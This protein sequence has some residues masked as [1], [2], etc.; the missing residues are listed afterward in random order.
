VRVRTGLTALLLCGCALAVRCGGTPTRLVRLPDSSLSV[1][2]GVLRLVKDRWNDARIGSPPA[3]TAPACSASVGAPPVIAGDFNGDGT[4]DLA[5]QVQARDGA[6][7]AVA[8]AR[9]KNYELLDVVRAAPAPM[10]VM[11]I[12]HRGAGYRTPDSAMDYFFS[13]DT[14]LVMPC[15]GPTTAYFWNGSG[16][17]PQTV[18]I[19]TP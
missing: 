7:L 11:A 1:P 14:L 18:T 4:Q 12:G 5:V 16:F 13:A 15:G 19:G 3:S 9:L 2:A 10:G 8:L 17:D 6:H